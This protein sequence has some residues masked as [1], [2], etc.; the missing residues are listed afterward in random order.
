MRA[1]LWSCTNLNNRVG[2]DRWCCYRLVLSNK[3]IPQDLFGSPPLGYRLVQNIFEW[4]RLNE[5]LKKGDWQRGNGD[6]SL[7]L[8]ENLRDDRTA[9][10][11]D[12]KNRRHWIRIGNWGARIRESEDTKI[13]KH[14][15]NLRWEDECSIRI[16]SC[17]DECGEMKFYKIMALNSSI[18]TNDQI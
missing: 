2:L 16:M 6:D 13:R 7:D 4:K 12:T 11:A 10:C 5:L 17:N 15:R 1:K 8:S 14:V 3:K 18:V 9:S